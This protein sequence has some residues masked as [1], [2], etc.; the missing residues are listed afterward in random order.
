[1]PITPL[2]FGLLAPINHFFPKKVSNISFVLVNVWIDSEAILYTVF[3][4]GSMDKG[5][6]HSLLGAFLAAFILS[7]FGYRSNP[8]I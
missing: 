6:E 1:M 5:G 3:G 4:T 8:W 7:L 2:H